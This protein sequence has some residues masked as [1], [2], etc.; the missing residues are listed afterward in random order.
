LK[1]AI[2]IA[3]YRDIAIAISR[4]FLR[5]ST[6]FPHNIQQADPAPAKA[7]ADTEEGMDIEQWMGYIADLQA[8]HSSHVAGMVYGWGIQEQAGT[9][10][11]RREMFWLSSTDWH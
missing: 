5:P 11:H 6:A 2:H 7:D 10:A 8:A 9:T 4:R 1:N 3:A